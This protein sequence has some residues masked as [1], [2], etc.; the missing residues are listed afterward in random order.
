MARALHVCAWWWGAQCL[1]SPRAA[2]NGPR[3]LRGDPP[4]APEY[5]EQLGYEWSQATDSVEVRVVTPDGVDA[6]RLGVDVVGN[7]LRVTVDD[8]VLL[9]G[10]LH[11]G[12]VASE[13]LW[14]LDEGDEDSGERP[15]VECTLL[16]KREGLWAVLFDGAPEMADADAFGGER[17]IDLGTVKHSTTEGQR[18]S[19]NTDDVF[20]FE[21]DSGAPEG[22]VLRVSS[23]GTQTNERIGT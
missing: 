6:R 17:T 13:T 1:V 3:P 4:N 12:V 23:V 16:K 5:L 20:E 7:R 19:D 22:T 9:D 2:R 11:G 18:L 15:F 10:A 14:V 8:A 21:F